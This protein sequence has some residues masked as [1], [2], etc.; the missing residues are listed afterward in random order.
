MA[1]IM[2]HGELSIVDLTDSRKLSAYLTSNLPLVVIYDPNSSTKYSPDWSANKLVLTPVIL[3]D[4]TSISVSDPSISVSWQK[5]EGTNAVTNLTTGETVS[6]GVLNVS[7][8][9]LANIA[10]GLLTYICTINYK[11]PDT[12][13]LVSTKVQ[14]SFSLVKNA[15]ELKDAYLTGEQ[16]FKYNGSG[17]LIS[18]STITITAHL[19]NT[20]VKQW[21]YKD[22]TGA[23]QAYPGAT[24]TTTLTV[25]D[26]D[27]VFN[28]DIAMIKLVTDDGSIYDI[29][30]IIKLRDG[31][32]GQSTLTCILSNEV[33]SVPCTSSGALYSTSLNGCTTT[34]TIYKGSSDDTANW[35]ITA[36]PSNGV[37]GTYD[38]TKRT[39][40]ITG[41]TVDS[42]YVEFTCTRSSYANIVKRFSINKDRSGA[43]GKNA[44]I[45]YLNTDVA[46]IKQNKSKVFSPTSIK[47]ESTRREGNANAA[48]YAGRFKIYESTDGGTNYTLKYTSSTEESSKSYTPSATNVTTLKGE[49]YV[50]G[51]TATLLDIQT[52]SVVSDGIDGQTGAAGKDSVNTIL[53]NTAEVIPCTTAGKAK[54]ARTITI[55][56]SCY[57]GVSRIA[58]KAVLGTLPSGVTLSK[59]QDA[60]ASADG[61]IQLTVAKDATLASTN[62]G[63][64]TITITAGGLSS[65]HKF[66][67]TKSLQASNGANAVLFQIFAPQGDRILNSSNN[68]VLQTQLTSGTSTVTAT[69]YQWEKYTSGNYVALTGKTASTLT[70]TPDMVD[71]LASFR[72]K[73]IYSSKTFYAYWTVTDVSDPV[74]INVICSIGDQLV[75]GQGV[76]AIYA[77]AYRNGEEIDPIKSNIFSQTQPGNPSAGDYYYAVNKTAK[78]VTL[79]KYS[80]TAWAAA[81]DSDQPKGTYTWTRRDKDGNPLDAAKPYATG[82][83]I[84]IDRDVVNKKMVFGCDFTM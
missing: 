30:E 74:V 29:H 4:N 10:S 41:L 15:A 20:S 6:K 49:L 24:A 44:V 52:I 11:D 17:T 73:A 65:Q 32:A 84:Y 39:Y 42:G 83:V 33:Q 57:K 71:S 60:T 36:T 79:M 66:T 35:K 23:W 75:N 82:K 69:S 76:G 1:K 26:T 31:A 48:A 37:T 13:S 5:Q 43:D 72:C 3:L 55:P 67:W 8:N 77:L 18:S 38:S 22:S 45:Y 53:G 70:V 7:N 62:S 59:N 63:D 28:K 12:A 64:I 16:T 50:A 81:P 25:K 9:M 58:G 78:S 68:V 54:E 34:I 47:F 46:V 19:T 56:Y 80:G 2:A 40:T 61:V 21:Q 51:G 14:I 27:A